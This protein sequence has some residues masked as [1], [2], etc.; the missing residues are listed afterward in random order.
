MS[1]LRIFRQALALSSGTLSYLIDCT[2][3][4]IIDVVQREFCFFCLRNPDF[5]TWKDAWKSFAKTDHEKGYIF[6]HD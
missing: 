2:R 4:E 1:E 6:P 5:E 3:Y